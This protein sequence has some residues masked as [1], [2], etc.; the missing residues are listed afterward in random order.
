MPQRQLS[1]EFIREW[2]MQQ[3]FQG[4][5]GQLI[6]DIHDDFRIEIYQRYEELFTKLTGHQFIPTDTRHF[7]TEL[8]QIVEPWTNK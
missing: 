7:M 5:D 3:G 4:L 2:L 1:K 8:P 6:P